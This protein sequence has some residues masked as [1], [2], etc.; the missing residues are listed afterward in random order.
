MATVS[1]ELI[2]DR[3]GK[4]IG[5]ID[6]DQYG[7]KTVRDFYGKIKGRY[8]KTSNTTIDFYGRIVSYGDATASLLYGK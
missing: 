4:I 8:K 7:N 3:T 5:R 6:T 1:K 2:R